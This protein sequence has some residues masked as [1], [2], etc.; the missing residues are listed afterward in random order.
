MNVFNHLSRWFG[1]KEKDGDVVGAQG[2]MVV[3]EPI[4]VN[5]APALENV[6]NNEEE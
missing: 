1:P 5:D 4:V 2:G 6:K 3:L